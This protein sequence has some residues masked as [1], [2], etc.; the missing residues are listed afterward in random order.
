MLSASEKQLLNEIREWEQELYRY[1]TNDLELT[2][3]KY[4]EQAFHL[5]PET[6]QEDFLSGLN[7]AMFHLHSLIQ[8]S[9]LYEDSRK[10][11]LKAARVFDNNIEDIAD[12]RKLPIDKLQYIAEQQMA[13][14]RLYSLAQGGLTGTGG[15]ILLA[16]DLPAIAFINLRVIQLIAMS[17]GFEVNSPYEMMTSIKVFH[18]STL[19]RRYRAIRWDELVAEIKEDKDKYFYEGKEDV[20]AIT[21]LEQPMKQLL[22][23]LAIRLFKNKKM[24]GIPIISIVI[25]ASMNY[26][27]T[28]NVTDFTQKF[29]QMRYLIEKEKER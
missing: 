26:Q 11:I 18:A 3:E 28:K 7:N 4:L 19:P 1:E 16:S 27:L 21:W 20:F 22:K 13:R 2:L 24:E 14:H 12:L 5:L 10:R 6:V 15:A 25:G 29:Y 9:D 8:G 17:Y 23:A